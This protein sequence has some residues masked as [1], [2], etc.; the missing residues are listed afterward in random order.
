MF[1]WRGADG[2]S[3]DVS[4][5]TI[6]RFDNVLLYDIVNELAN[7]KWIVVIDPGR[8][9]DRDRTEVRARAKETQNPKYR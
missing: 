7:T 5:E 2:G 6:A 1:L 4:I 8:R 9:A 3:T